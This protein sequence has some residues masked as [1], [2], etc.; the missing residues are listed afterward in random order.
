MIKQEFI[1]TQHGDLECLSLCPPE[2]V[3]SASPVILVH[4]IF[5]GASLF[6]HHFMPAIAHAGY[7]C[8]ALSLRS[9]GN[10]HNNASDSPLE[11]YVED[12]RSLFDLVLQRHKQ[13]PIIV[14]YSMGGLV[15][16]HFASKLSTKYP[17]MPLSGLCLLASVPPH[18]F[19]HLN[20]HLVCSQPFEA[21][22]LSQ[23]MLM[24][25]LL[26]QNAYVRRSL[27]NALFHDGAT[28]AQAEKI[29][30]GFC[31]EDLNLFSSAQPVALDFAQK[32]PVLVIGAQ[33][34]KIVPVKIVNDTA[35]AYGV[36]AE[37]IPLCGHAIPLENQWPNAMERLITW[38]HERHPSHQ[39]IKAS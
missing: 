39:L 4:G 36:K 34:D 9:H 19:N 2:T 29:L 16:Q 32:L 6:S 33:N 37:I 30:A 20:N 13:P 21:S 31:P 27:L 11:S 17:V 23:F 38:V 18:G 5:T 28:K 3:A 26:V 10:S 24:P 22:V 1:A 25:E 12:L 8:Y 14:G 7:P 35:N 15:A